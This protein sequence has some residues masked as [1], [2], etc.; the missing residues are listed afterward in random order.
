MYPRR[1]LIS[2]EGKVGKFA[3]FLPRLG[4]RLSFANNFG[5]NPLKINWRCLLS[6]SDRVSPVFGCWTSASRKA[7]LPFRKRLCFP[8]YCQ[9]IAPSATQAAWE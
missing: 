2:G 4:Y 6:E 5:T 9:Q 8:A 1:W 3:Q 7:V